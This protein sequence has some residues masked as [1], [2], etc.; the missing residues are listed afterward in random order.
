MRTDQ[1]ELGS[2]LHTYRGRHICEGGVCDKKESILW[3]HVDRLFLDGFKLSVNF[4]PAG[5]AIRL[6]V[7]GT[8]NHH[9]DFTQ[10]GVFRLGRKAQAN[11][12]DLYQFIVSKI[13]GRQW[14]KLT[15]DI[16][17]GRTVSFDQFHI[18]SSAISRKKFFRGYNTIDLDRITG[19]DFCSA[20][21]V[22]DYIDAKGRGKRTFLGPVSQIPNVHLAQ[23]F[24]SAMARRNSGQ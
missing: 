22:V 1:H 7:V 21:F 2:I 23:A 15:K 10:R 16:A 11:F 5:E 6:R 14:S 19:C 20:Q 3:D 24:L 4:L 18:S 9:I 8:T 12:W 17:D 13:I